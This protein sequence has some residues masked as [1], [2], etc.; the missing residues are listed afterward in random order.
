MEEESLVEC[1][2]MVETL[3]VDMRQSEYGNGG[4]FEVTIL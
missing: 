2:V 4:N 3:N 1:R